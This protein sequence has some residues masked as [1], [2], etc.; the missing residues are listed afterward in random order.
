MLFEC[1]KVSEEARAQFMKQTYWND[2]IRKPMTRLFYLSYIYTILRCTGI[3]FINRENIDRELAADDSLMPL[4]KVFLIYFAMHT[5]LAHNSSPK[6]TQKFHCIITNIADL[7]AVDHAVKT[8]CSLKL[9]G[10]LNE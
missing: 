8:A 9:L 10:F 6:L 4:E 7:L 5:L 2:M 3:Y 1:L